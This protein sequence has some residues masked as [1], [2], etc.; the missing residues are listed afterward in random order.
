MND[1]H[2]GEHFSDHRA[3]IGHTILA[4]AR[5]AADAAAKDHDGQDHHRNADDKPDCE[6]GQ[7]VEQVNRA[8][9]AKKDIVSATETVVPTTVSIIAVSD[10]MRLEI[11]LGEFSS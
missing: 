8:A 6:A 7:Q 2:G 10:G 4:I 5:N 9:D 3:H 11:S 1:F